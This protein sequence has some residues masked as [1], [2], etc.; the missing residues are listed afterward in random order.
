MKAVI[1][2]PN[3]DSAKEGD[4]S[5][6]KLEEFEKSELI[7]FITPVFDKAEI[8]EKAVKY[9]K[10]NGGDPSIVS[11]LELKLGSEGILD[12]A[13]LKNIYGDEYFE[14][15]KDATYKIKLSTLFPREGREEMNAKLKG[16][17]ADTAHK[18][19]YV[20]GRGNAAKVASMMG[21]L[22]SNWR[23]EKIS[24]TKPSGPPTE[25]N[26]GGRGVKKAMLNPQSPG[27]VDSKLT[28]KLSE[29]QG[30]KIKEGKLMKKSLKFADPEAEAFPIYN[31]HNIEKAVEYFGKP[32]FYEDYEPELR[33]SVALNIAK[34]AKRY[35]M[36]VSPEWLAKFGLKRKDDTMEK[37]EFG[38][39]SM[40]KLMSKVSSLVSSREMDWADVMELQKG[41]NSGNIPDRFTH[42]VVDAI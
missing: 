33:K 39:V 38:N 28:G 9:V 7:E 35:D 21:Q 14:K 36:D 8:V 5:M 11:T 19:I 13:L 23:K 18:D 26:L 34:A 27:D 40:S 10:E 37:S 29:G 42:L 4:N 41:I 32:K 15:A 12:E 30:Q 22:G 25:D 3:T 16:Y 31:G 20:K 6:E 1:N 24:S 2:K 17:G